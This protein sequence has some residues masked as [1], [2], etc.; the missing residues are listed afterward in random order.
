M[1]SWPPIPRLLAES[2]KPPPLASTK[3]LIGHV[4]TWLE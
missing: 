4:K 3:P 2:A 1:V